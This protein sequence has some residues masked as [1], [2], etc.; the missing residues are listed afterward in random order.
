MSTFR[1]SLEHFKQI[2]RE[3][4]LEELKQVMSMDY[5]ARE[6]RGDEIVDFGYDQSIMGWEQGFD[7]VGGT[8]NVEWDIKEVGV[9]P[10]KEE[11]CMAILS[12]TIRQD[13]TSLETANLFFHTFQQN[14]EG[15]WKL[16]RSYI[17]AGITKE[18]IHSLQ[19]T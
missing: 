13:G 17:E 10:L 18:N 8:E 7:Y 3:S 9:L 1:E 5:Q 6:V 19:V 2:W 15:D 14:E 4:S 16:V 12:A 11:E